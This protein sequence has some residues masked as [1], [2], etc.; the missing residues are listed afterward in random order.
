MGVKIL[1]R[2]TVCDLLKTTAGITEIRTLYS[3]RLS[4]SVVSA[5][6]FWNDRMRD[7][8]KQKQEVPSM[9]GNLQ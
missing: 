3:Y 9:G 4:V 7:S 2:A 6:E 1:R 8:W 5:K